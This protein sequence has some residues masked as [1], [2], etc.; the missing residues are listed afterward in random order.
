MEQE[1]GADL[2]APLAAVTDTR[3]ERRAAVPDASAER[4]AAAEAWRI[5]LST[6]PESAS[7]TVSARVALPGPVR[8]RVT[9]HGTG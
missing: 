2:R 8:R 6:V 9:A 7:A 3:A 1:A 5:P 4:K